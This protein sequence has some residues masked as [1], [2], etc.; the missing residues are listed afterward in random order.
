MQVLARACGH[1]QLADFS[2][3]NLTTFRREIA[4]LSGVR[5]SGLD[6]VAGR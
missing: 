6:P 4:D 3:D 5:F 1:R 2:S